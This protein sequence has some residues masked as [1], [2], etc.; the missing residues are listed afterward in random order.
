MNTSLLAQS[1]HCFSVDTEEVGGY[2]SA[3]SSFMGS[4]CFS[5]Y[6][7]HP[8]LRCCYRVSTTFVPGCRELVLTAPSRKARITVYW[9]MDDR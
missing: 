6:A 7:A 9:D 2:K 3:V 5:S 4:T 1:R 8:T